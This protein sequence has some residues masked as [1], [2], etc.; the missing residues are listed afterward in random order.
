MYL[1]KQPQIYDIFKIRVQSV[2][3]PH[4]PVNVHVG[5]EI[6]FKIMDENI[7]VPEQTDKVIWSSNNP[8]VLDINQ[9]TG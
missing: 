8:S 4:S 1:L 5:A 3:R 9:K 6:S 7:A 2:V